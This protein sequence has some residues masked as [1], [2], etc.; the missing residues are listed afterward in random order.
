M[1]F[2]VLCVCVCTYEHWFLQWLAFRDYGKYSAA[3]YAKLKSE[4]LS[5]DQ[6]FWNPFEKE[7]L[8]KRRR[9]YILKLLHGAISGL[10]YMHDHDRLHQSLGPASVVVKYDFHTFS[11]SCYIL[12]NF[13]YFLVTLL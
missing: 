12:F 4:K 13:Q 1:F 11:Y 5:Q 2:Y 8:I 6:N 9:F 3:D 7:Q 10:A